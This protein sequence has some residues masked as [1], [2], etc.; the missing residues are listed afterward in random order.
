MATKKNETQPL[1]AALA[2]ITVPL[3]GNAYFPD[4]VWKTK[5]P[6]G[7]SIARDGAKFTCT[8][9]IGDKD[10]GNAQQF[11]W[12]VNGKGSW[13]SVDIGKK[14][15]SKTITVDTSQFI[16]TG[17]KKFT[18][19]DF[20]VRGKRKTFQENKGTKKKP[21]YIDYKPEWSD[22][23]E[24]SF[25]INSAKEPSVTA[26]WGGTSNPYATTF[27]WSVVS[28]THAPASGIEWETMLV[29]DCNETDGSKLKWKTSALGY[30]SGTT[31]LTGSRTITEN[32]ATIVG[33][34]KS[35]TRWLRVRARGWGGRSGGDAH[36]W[37]YAKHVY[38]TPQTISI[39]DVTMSIDANV[40]TCVTTWEAPA[41]AAH[42][43]D[44]TEVQW[45]I[46]TPE[47]HC[48]C[49]NDDDWETAVTPKD[50][51]GKD[52]ARFSIESLV[53]FDQCL[54]VRIRTK[55][56][57]NYGYSEPKLV[58]KGKLTQ[59]ES[60]SVQTNSGTYTATITA[61]NMS[62]V[63][64]S[65]LAVLFRTEKR[66]TELTKSD[67]FIGVINAQPNQSGSVTAQC[68]DWSNEGN[69]SFGV[70]A[71]TAVDVKQYSY[72]GQS[73][74]KLWPYATQKS[75]TV[76]QGGSVPIAPSNFEAI[77]SDTAGEIIT[78][79]TWAWNQAD[80]TELSWS[81][82]P[83]AW[84]STQEPETYEV[85][86]L[87]A[88]RWRLSDLETGVRWYVRA[89]LGK[90]NEDDI[91]WGPYCEAAEVDLTT[92]PRTPAL[93]IDPPVITAK[94]SVKAWWAYASE[95]GTRQSHAVICQA[96]IDGQGV[97]TYGAQL[98]HTTTAQQVTISAQ[99]AGWTVGNTYLLC[100]KVTS[101]SGKD[102]EWSE[103]VAVT[104]AEPVT[105]SITQTSLSTVTLEDDDQNEREVLSLT[106]LPLTVT[107]EGAGNGGTTSLIIERAED[108]IMQ[109]P[110]ES[111]AIG[112]EGETIYVHSQQ[113]ESQITIEQDD[114]IGI[115][116]DG[117]KYRII[118]TTSDRLGQTASDTLEFEVHW[119]HQALLPSATSSINWT[120]YVAYI[121]P[122]APEGAVTGDTFDIYRLSV[123]KPELIVQNGEW[124]VTY[125]DPYPTLG[126]F[127]GH[128]VVFK[129][130][131]GDYITED[132]TMAFLDMQDVYDDLIELPMAVINFGGDRVE[133]E[134][135]ITLANAWKKDFQETRYL[136]GSIQGDWNLGVSR[137]LNMTAVMIISDDPEQVQAMRR[138][139]DYA[140]I[141]HVRTP[142][143]SSFAADV[144]V[145][146]NVSFD[147]AGDLA[148]F[149][150]SITKVAPETLDG[151]PYDQ[152]LTEEG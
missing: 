94:G 32:S 12:R 115:F 141:C 57:I 39:H 105:C 147:K 96:S 139:A 36:A 70:Y 19:F 109:R 13:T 5:A 18:S 58:T 31:G 40:I 124:G 152:W 100:V 101:T 113:G 43:I 87:N 56:D 55:H 92:T 114:L 90:T 3:L 46:D 28:D 135:N 123:D 15:V 34:T 63:E 74:Y 47:A 11:Q 8:W 65:K 72:K 4:M 78:S 131:N 23:S 126:A 16:P 150:L 95:D 81:Q 64:D 84:E 6:S 62:A 26:T 117:A 30:N 29:K 68:P 116:D 52:K 80:V 93:M 51:A 2:P 85:S 77:P 102:A 118:A 27:N 111:T 97:I 37:K 144:Q 133:F 35:Y 21:I 108:Y 106:E 66:A 53:S 110:D 149:S 69:I 146:E 104:V 148:S 48:Q 17:T 119:T 71:F 143:G 10:Y 98:A 132:S 86:N 89:R 9:K 7:L 99:R 130:L 128:R 22:W 25:A 122:T 145:S 1:V 79:W 33:K 44:L 60:L 49:P 83:N 121:T 140:G 50:T 136:G 14:T 120:E 82:N 76:W 42:P 67:I 137:T 103:P 142:E 112:Y 129:T 107:V 73:M 138:L 91:T 61:T 41:D 38:S 75:S 20:R 59:P 54:W 24:K 88:P 45:R 125:V 127:G 151:I 134:Y